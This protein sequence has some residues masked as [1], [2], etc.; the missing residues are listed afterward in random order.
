MAEI[1]NCFP[2]TVFK[3]KLGLASD[4]RRRIGEAVIDNYRQSPKHG[5]SKAHAW[6]GDRNGHEFLHKQD[7]YTDMF[8]AMHRGLVAYVR[9]LSIDPDRLDFLLTRSWGT[10][11]ESGQSIARHRHNQSHISI[12][13]YPLKAERT[14]NLIFHQPDPMNEFSPGLFE[15]YCHDIGLMTQSNH[16]NSELVNL[17]VAED[18]IVIFPSKTFHATEANQTNGVRISIAVDVVVTLLDSS[19]VEFLMP[20]VAAWRSSRS[21]DGGTAE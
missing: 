5:Q 7:L 12:V 3:D 17:P 6:T 2:L 8:R 16:F 9:A 4:Y 1:L 11:S 21:F 18:D 13:Y 15:P 20:P 14:G 19:R 10:V